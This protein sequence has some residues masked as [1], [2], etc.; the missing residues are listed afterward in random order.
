MSEITNSATIKVTAD[1]S[2]VESE[3]RKVDDAAAKTGRNLD[4]LG[5]ADG[6]SKLGENAEIAASKFGFAG[7]TII[8]AIQKQ[9]LA[10]E[11]GT[12]GTK[13]FFETWANQRGINPAILKPYLDQLD[14]VKTKAA[15]ATAAQSRMNAGNSF[16]EGLRSQAESIGKT[17]S[18]LLAM[19]A[20]QLGVSEAAGPLIEQ[21]RQAEEATTGFGSSAGGAADLMAKLVAAVSLG[22]IGGWVKGAIDAADSLKDLSKSTAISVRDLAG[23]K[24]ASQQ[25]GAEL[26]DTAKSI[27]K[28]SVNIGKDAD[29]YAKLGITAKEPLEAFKQLSDIFNSIDDPQKRAAFGAEALGKAWEG[30]A[31]LLSE[32]SKR[33]GEMVSRGTELSGMTEKLTD[34]ADDFNDALAEVS[35]GA[36]AVSGRI[37]ISLLPIL[38]AVADDMTDVATSSNSLSGVFATALTE[39]F[40]TVVILG[41]NVSYVLKTVGTEIGGMAAQLAA[42][43]T[44]DFKGFSAIGDVMKQD[45]EEGRAAFDQ[46]EKKIIEAGTKVREAAKNAASG[47]TVGDAV[48][49]AAKKAN[50]S[51]VDAF[52]NSSAAAAASAKNTASIQKE[53][54]AYAS[55]SASIAEKIAASEMEANGQGKIADSTKLLI[56]LEKQLE[57]GRLKLTPLQEQSYRAQ[58][59]Q[60]AVQEQIIAANKAQEESTKNV[61]KAI[62]ALEDDRAATYAS[63]MA[64]TLANEKLADTFGMTKEAI[65]AVTL[66]RMEDRLAQSAALELDDKEVSQLERL[67]AAKKRSIVSIGKVETM[68]GGKKALD[69]LDKFLDPARAKDFGEA[70]SDAFGTA[71][72][73]LGKLVD[74]LDVYGKRQ[75]EIEKQKENAKVALTSGSLNE[76]DYAKKVGELNQINAKNQLSS[77]GQMAGAAAGFFDEQSKGYRTL[78]AVSQVFHAAELAMTLAELVPKGIS[79]VLSQGQGDPYTAFGRMAAMAAAV[80]GLGVAVG[81]IGSSGKGGAT[82]AEVQKTQG[83]GTVFGDSSAKSESIARLLGLIEKNTYQGLDYFPSMTSSL[84][85]IETSMGGLGNLIAGTVGLTDGK[86]FGVKEGQIGK[87]GAPT[88]ALSR[89]GTEVTKALFGPGLGDK[90][91]GFI[92]NLYGKTTQKIVDS[93]ISFGGSLN[94]LQAGKGY[95]QYA[96]V[97]TTK[98]KLFGLSKKTTNSLQTA[99][100]G[101]ELSD[102]FGMIFTGLEGTLRAAAVTLGLSADGVSNS[103]DSLVL[104]ATTLSLKDLKGAD[105]TAA[106]NA[107]ISGALDEI[108]EAAFPSFAEFR[109]LGEGF[110]ETVVRV[111]TGY[112]AINTVF[113]SFGKS[114]GKVGLDALTASERLIEMSGGLERFTSQGAYFLENFFSEKEQADALR[115][116]IQPTLNN[117]GLD[118]TSE[119]A[120]K[121][122]RDVIVA[123]DTTTSAGADAYAT[124]MLIAPAFQDIVKSTAGIFEQRKDLL[125]QLD[126]LTLSPAQ[127]LAKQRAKIDPSN[128]DLFDQVQNTQAQQAAERTLAAVNR[129]YQDQIDEFV[130]G[131]LTVTQV[132]ELEIAGMDATTVAL[133]DQVAALKQVAVDVAA[134]QAKVDG[135]ASANAGFQQQIDAILKTTMSAADLREFETK[136]M[137]ASTV[138]LYDRLKGLEAEQVAAQEAARLA[139][140]AAAAQ[141]QAAAAA[142][143]A[144]QALREAYKSVTD[145]IFDEVARIR[146]LMGTK[147]Q[148]FAGAQSAFTIASAQ[149]RSGDFDAAKMLPQ[150]SQTLLSLAEDSA[151][152]LLDLQRIRAQTAASLATTGNL[153]ANMGG[154]AQRP[155]SQLTTP[156][157][158]ATNIFTDRA[159]SDEQTRVLYAS[160]IRKAP[161]DPAALEAAKKETADLR[162]EM[163]SIAVSSAKT[164]SLLAR[165]V[166]NNALRISG[167]TV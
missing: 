71:G 131:I 129:G 46:W 158:L 123:L 148:T 134:A 93:G 32:G 9:T 2:G 159:A 117:F 136:G 53:A 21:L 94:D 22:A 34:D 167:E 126:E 156:P 6:I 36:A 18:E 83:A 138:A 121:A 120:T 103:L 7:K 85:N 130:K 149:A 57:S 113:E 10:A 72:S 56:S 12:K 153:V 60:Y 4:N 98:T 50:D 55:L 81:S 13:E 91:A 27:N 150:L 15:E 47:D 151:A 109:K 52:I 26:E 51:K 67:I 128:V 108:S 65:E 75:A 42:L 104:K 157:A 76:V 77:Y 141:Q 107:V 84:R 125:A 1:A 133:Y 146:G 19:R 116:R 161:A 164:A 16:V 105:L 30:A 97:D 61:A 45:A 166:D 69:E 5:R 33:I 64:E 160:M 111:A 86:G 89:A 139:A 23:L 78:Q 8:D 29:K 31:P 163:Q 44:F 37:A 92:N 140:E 25:A 119:D 118:A 24:V 122:F 143:Q 82:A 90:I 41:G 110:A 112:Q 68:T 20:A 165:V 88:D 135:I 38:K 58:I 43:A 102:Q 70:L 144:S 87:V 99:G 154:L 59:K 66:A 79:A 162:A 114:F 106:I 54:S 28:L 63:A 95:N 147:D 14:A 101:A 11:R 49:A 35:A 137:D 155:V 115:K 124:L 96:S 132:R 100:L 73:S 127:M 17:S 152:S 80:A 48:A 74:Q 3:L 62:A 40:R 39:A 145:S 142:E